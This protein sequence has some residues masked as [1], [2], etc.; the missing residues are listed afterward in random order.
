LE[1]CKDAVGGLKAIYFMNYADVTG[2]TYLTTAGNEDVIEA[3]TGSPSAYKYELKGANNFEQN[4][5]SSRENGTTFVEQTL[6]A[7]IKKQDIATHKQ[8]KLLS[9]G[10]PRVIVED[11][12]SNFWLMG[13]DNGAE[14]T[15][16]AISTGTAMGDLS[17]ITLT[18]TA[19]EKIPAPF[20]DCSSESGLSGNG[21]TVVSGT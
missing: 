11:Y 1:P 6:T 10:R 21:I 4:L 5:T 14:V 20:L 3:V 2:I 9:F 17:G 15:T 12:N 8:I 19:T 16:A 7:V 13:V 18:L